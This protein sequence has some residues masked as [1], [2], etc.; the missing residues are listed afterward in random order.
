MGENE[1]ALSIVAQL[2]RHP[3]NQLC[4]DCQRQPPKWASINLGIFLC[5]DCGGIHRSLGSH[6]SFIRSVQ[7]DTWTIDQVNLMARVGN[8]VANEYWEANLPDDFQR[9]G[10]GFQ[11]LMSNFIREKYVQKKF[12]A[13]GPPPT[14]S[15]HPPQQKE[16]RR[17]HHHHRHEA[18][19]PPKPKPQEDPYEDD[20]FPVIA[21]DPPPY[22]K[23]QPK[24]QLEKQID[25]FFSAH[26]ITAPPEKFKAPPPQTQIPEK[27]KAPIHRKPG[28]QIPMRL[29]K[30]LKNQSTDYAAFRHQKGNE[31][32]DDS[33]DVFS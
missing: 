22:Q 19:P 27:S 14:A 23:E 4:A 33:D 28:V 30:K 13:K 11:G 31:Y 29:Q 26:D 7:F 20:F 24:K 16:Q 21:I 10:P 12:T 15:T 18:P 17:K 32:S 1:K 9:P 3:D 6:I 5:I 25:D 8:R 2:L